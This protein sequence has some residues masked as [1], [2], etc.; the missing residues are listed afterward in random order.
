MDT[1]PHQPEQSGNSKKLLVVIEVWGHW[2][3]VGW[4][5]RFVPAWSFLLVSMLGFYGLFLS[6]SLIEFI[7]SLIIA[8]WFIFYLFYVFS[9]LCSSLWTP[10]VFPFLSFISSIILLLLLIKKKKK[11]IEP[12]MFV[13]MALPK[14]PTNRDGCWDI[15]R[16]ITNPAKSVTSNLDAS[17]P[18]IS[19]G[20]VWIV[21]EASGREVAESLQIQ[22]YFLDFI[23]SGIWLEDYIY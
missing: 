17:S 16:T 13:S 23:L 19:Y 12:K 6:S 21:K 1:W 3:D 7:S 22:V 18:L 15:L 20:S 5:K 11:S 14:P 2:E 10:F 8:S 4:V 9:F